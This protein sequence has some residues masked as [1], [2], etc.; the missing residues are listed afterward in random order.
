[1]FLPQ[2]V[3]SARVMKMSVSYL[4]PFLEAEKSVVRTNGKILMATVKGDVHDIG[5]NIVGV[6][7]ACNNYEIIDLGVMVPANKILAAAKEHSVDVIGL[8]G[9]ITPSLDEMVGVATEME[10]LGIRLPLLIGGATTSKTHTAVKIAPCYSGTTIHVPDASHS[11]G[12][13]SALLSEDKSRRDQYQNNVLSLYDKIRT[14]HASRTATKEYVPLDFAQS[15][16]F[17]ID[18]SESHPSVPAHPGIHQFDSVGVDVLRNYIDWT[19]FFTSWQLAGK[20][21]EILKDSVVGEEARSLFEHAQQML[22]DITTGGWL[23]PSGITGLFPANRH[24]DDVVIYSDDSRSNELTRFHFLRQQRKKAPGKPYYCLADFVAPYEAG[25]DWI[26]AFAVTTGHGIESHVSRFQEGHDDYSIIMLKALADRL[27][28]AFAEYLHE[29]VRKHLWGYSRTEKL[30]NPEL[31]AEKYPGIRPAPGYPA[32]PDH[33][34]KEILWDLLDVERSTGIVLT[35][36]MAMY[37]T[38]AVSGFYF[39][40]PQSRYFGLGSILQD[41]LENYAERKQM[42]VDRVAAWLRQN[43]V[44]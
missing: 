44:E 34:E 12:V 23:K 25:C 19:P 4:T 1:M 30:T 29:H 36:S 7:L 41:Q 31:I 20:Y 16:G 26:G 14:D 27:A 10:R 21:P 32:C 24:G 28:E 43:L 42:S 37:P 39:A 3:K 13:V 22:D 38:A 40:H 35:E 18:W 15:N 2:V 11:V 33:T 8:S 5:K 6:V 17:S 9:L